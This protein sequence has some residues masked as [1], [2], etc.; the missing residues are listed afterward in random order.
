MTRFLV[1]DALSSENLRSRPKAHTME[2]TYATHNSAGVTLSHWQKRIMFGCFVCT[3]MMYAGRRDLNAV[4]APFLQDLN[5]KKTQY[6]SM[7][8]F[9]SAAFLF[10][11]LFGGIAA[12]LYVTPR[13]L[14]ITALI[15]CGTASI[16][17]SASSSPSFLVLLWLLNGLSQGIGWIPIAKILGKW[18]TKEQRATKWAIAMA[19]QN[20]AGAM[21]AIVGTW[22]ASQHGW[23]VTMI[24]FGSIIAASS[25]VAVYHVTDTPKEAG[26]THLEDKMSP[27]IHLDL[28]ADRKTEHHHVGDVDLVN[29]I[30]KNKVV[31]LLFLSN[32][33]MYTVRISILDWIL[34]F[35]M[36]SRGLTT[37]GASSCVFWFELFSLAGGFASSYYS[38]KHCKGNRIPACLYFSAGTALWCVA[39]Y[40][41]VSTSYFVN[42]FIIGM[43]GFF[44]NG[45]H[46]LLA[47]AATEL[48][49]P[50]ASGTSLG[51]IGG[52]VGAAGIAAGM[53]MGMIIRDQGWNVYV[54]CLVV[55]STMM[56]VCCFILH[57][58]SEKKEENRVQQDEHHK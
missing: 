34:L 58:D 3:F 36:E 15:M 25:A 56:T 5:L 17:I 46:T 35:A 10:S 16:F 7:S 47:V 14:L 23:R 27:A 20:I 28:E 2:G 53:P 51:L 52:A 6:G 49:D 18:Y 50:R 43:I 40:S 37:T 41:F 9:F 31:W 8:S 55:T 39:L 54:L 30:F 12:D 45:P 24:S 29:M 26:F 42:V 57:T 11:K 48:V 38:D 13:N 22:I 19:A 1:T 21:V 44:L 32:L 4:L 33:C